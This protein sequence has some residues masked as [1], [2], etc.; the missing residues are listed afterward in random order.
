MTD[1]TVGQTPAPSPGLIID[2]EAT[3]L[4][5]HGFGISRWNG[6][7]I[8]TPDH[9][10][11]EKARVQLQQRQ[12]SRWRARLYRCCVHHHRGNVRH[13]SWPRNV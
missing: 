2:V 10:P 1:R 12:R 8:V 4:D 7:V 6:W 13:A 9:L 11:G 5:Q 3:D